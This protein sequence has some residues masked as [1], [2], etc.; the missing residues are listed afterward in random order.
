MPTVQSSHTKGAPVACWYWTSPGVTDD[1]LTT[2]TDMLFLYE[3]LLLS[4]TVTRNPNTPKTV[5]V[6][7]RTPEELSVSPFG[8][9]LALNVY[10]PAPPAAAIVWLYA[11]FNVAF[12]RSAG[13][14]TRTAYALKP[15]L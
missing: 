15:T 13:V 3:A 1:G 6:P 4:K 7:E 5:G 11:V 9:P 14:V 8:N 10:P 2:S 12:G